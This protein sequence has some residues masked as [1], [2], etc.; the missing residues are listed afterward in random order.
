[1]STA[2]K[3]ELA[4]PVL[5][6]SALAAATAFGVAFEMPPELNERDGLAG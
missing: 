3:T 6:D 1:L 2:E 5:S 4:F